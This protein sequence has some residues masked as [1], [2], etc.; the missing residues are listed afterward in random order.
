[1]IVDTLQDMQTVATYVKNSGASMNV[2]VDVDP[3]DAISAVKAG[4][5]IVSVIAPDG[6]L[7]ALQVGINRGGFTTAW[8]VRWVAGSTMA[9]FRALFR[10][11]ADELV[12]RSMGTTPVYW[13]KTG[14]VATFAAQQLGAR[15]NVDDS[16]LPIYWF[17]A[18]EAIATGKI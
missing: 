10:D 9:T 1:M 4:R 11:L 3:G 18:N 5:A 16:G 6:A 2:P 12:R 17:T 14:T 13:T 8:G 15:S 7:I